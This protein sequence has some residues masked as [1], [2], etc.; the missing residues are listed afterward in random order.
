MN[1]LELIDIYEAQEL[2][3]IKERTTF[4]V[5]EV[6]QIIR[7]MANQARNA[8]YNGEFIFNLEDVENE[9]ITVSDNDFNMKKL[10]S[11]ED[12]FILLLQMTN[13]PDGSL[14]STDMEILAEQLGEAVKKTKNVHGVLLLPPNFEISL[15]TAV[16]NIKDYGTTLF[17]DALSLEE[18]NQIVENFKKKVNIEYE[19]IYSPDD[20]SFDL[21]TLNP[22]EDT[23]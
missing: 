14:T 16:T 20:F 1:P 21:N 2:N 15:L 5:D 9:S 3:K 7:N 4:G 10:I 18:M 23:D 6:E 12:G 22:S 19:A 17:D 13:V 8:I 11:K